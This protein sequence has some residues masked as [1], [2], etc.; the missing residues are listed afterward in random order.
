MFRDHVPRLDQNT[1]LQH[2]RV[3]WP[4]LNTTS[5]DGRVEKDTALR[6]GR[7]LNTHVII[8]LRF[9]ASYNDYKYLEQH[10]R[11]INSTVIGIVGS[12]GAHI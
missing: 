7:V 11:M 5:Q 8:K 6:C 9:Q 2:S 10:Y 4:D 1:A 3:H 12:H